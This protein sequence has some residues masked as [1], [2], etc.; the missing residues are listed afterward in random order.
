[1]ARRKL[2]R[3]AKLF[4]VFFDLKLGRSEQIAALRHMGG[5]PK[6]STLLVEIVSTFLCAFCK[7]LSLG[8]GEIALCAFSRVINIVAEAR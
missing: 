6:T 3:S 2:G 8:E 4:V 5:C 7:K 1:M